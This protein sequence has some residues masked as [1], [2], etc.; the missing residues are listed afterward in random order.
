MYVGMILLVIAA[1]LVLF[2]VGQ[3]VLDR[4]RLTDRQA[5]VW[6]AAILIGGF[7]P[8]IALGS[9]FAMN[10][11]GFLVPLGLCV[12]LFVKADTTGERGRAVVSAVLS[13]ALVW[14]I[15]VWFPNEPET[16]PFDVNYLYGIAAGVL[17]CILGRSRRAAFIGGAMGIIL[18][19]VA[20]GIMNWANGIDQTLVLGGAG[21]FDA[22]VISAFTAVL[23][24]ELVGEAQERMTRETGEPQRVFEDGEIHQ[25]VLGANREDEDEHPEEFSG[26]EYLY[27]DEMEEQQDE[28]H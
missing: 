8:N 3:R 17:A 19:D 25:A 4:M 11:G 22:I 20:Q 9:R 28:R 1:I 18:A 26:D 24:R 12:Y 13:G 23:L 27:D 7:I 5:L 6:M 16:M 10:I 2:G 15:G 21:G 14:A